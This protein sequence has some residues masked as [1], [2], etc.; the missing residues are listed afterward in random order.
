MHTA[1]DLEPGLCKIINFA[2]A[3]FCLYFL[4]PVGW[5]W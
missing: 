1:A 5:L 2:A 3:E 4:M